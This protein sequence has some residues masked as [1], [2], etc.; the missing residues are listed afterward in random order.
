MYKYIIVFLL[1]LKSGKITQL[2]LM[3]LYIHTE[4]GQNVGLAMFCNFILMKTT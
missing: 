4:R 2:S 1:Y 3:G